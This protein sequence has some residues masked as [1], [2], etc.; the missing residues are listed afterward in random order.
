MTLVHANPWNDF[1]LFSREFN[2]LFERPAARAQA[3]FVAPLDVYE[4]E[5]GY[6]LSLDLPGVPVSEVQIEVVDNRL[7]LRGE[8]KLDNADKREGYHRIERSFGSFTRTLVL[9][10][11]VDVDGIAAAGK[12]GV[13]TLTLPKKPAAQPRRIEIKA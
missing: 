8:R 13:L 1:D 12:D 3:G 9:P 4:D 2:R 11:D 5:K 10:K 6:L 7:S